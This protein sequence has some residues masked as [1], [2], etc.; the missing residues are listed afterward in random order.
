MKTELTKRESDKIRHLMPES[1]RDK[2]QFSLYD[3]LDE[4]TIPHVIIYS[5]IEYYF[6]ITKLGNGNYLFSYYKADGNFHSKIKYGEGEEI[7]DA[8]ADYL[9]NVEA[10]RLLNKKINADID[11]IMEL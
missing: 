2:E 1:I 11:F 9:L 4:N 6:R 3:L 5:N 10:T 7:I 8:L